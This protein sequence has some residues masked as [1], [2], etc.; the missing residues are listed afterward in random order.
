MAFF[1]RPGYRGDTAGFV[2]PLAPSGPLEISNVFGPRPFGPHVGSTGYDYDFHR[3]IDFPDGVEGNPVYSAVAGA[4]IRRVYSHFHWG[5]A[6]QLDEFEEA[7]PFSSISGLSVSGGSL[8]FTCARVGVASFPAQAARLQA[9]NE[10]IFVNKD[11]WVLEVN[12]ASSI[13][14]NGQFGLG[15]FNSTLS[16]YIALDYDGTTFTFRGQHDGGAFTSDGT[17][18]SV[19]GSTWLRIVYTVGTDTISWEHSSDGDSWTILG[20][21]TGLTFTEYSWTPSLYW[22]SQDTNATPDTVPV[23]Q[24]NWVDEAQTVGRFG[25][26]VSICTGYGKITQIHCASLTVDL[27]EFVVAGQQIGTVG[28][29]GFNA[30]S[31]R[32]N[33]VHVHL[34]WSESTTWSYDQDEALNPLDSTLLPRTDT[35]TNVTA[36][37]TNE[38]D[39]GST[40]SWRL[41][42]V[43][44][45]GDADF[46]LDQVTLVGNLGSRTVDF[47]SRTGLNADND[48]PVAN[49]VYIVPEDFDE[50][51][52]AYEVSFYFDRSVVGTTF[53]SAEVRDT[54]DNLLASL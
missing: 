27:G 6:G 21:E 22:L 24:F 5:D 12:F 51:D 28:R 38:N 13:S 47:N 19:A 3:G 52:A 33:G 30:R 34:E 4:V 23:N 7:D 32:V 16:E 41:R 36:F 15:V 49:G 8:D 20:S 2:N 11:D 35:T 14:L 25:N 45:R 37:V 44:A 9:T 26:W 10:S 31:G 43:V 29:T 42:V 46:D 53:V 50:L 18:Y 48:I 1:R 39:P 17:T 54:Q 40:D